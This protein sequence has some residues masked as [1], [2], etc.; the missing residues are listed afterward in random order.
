MGSSLPAIARSVSWN[1]REFLRSVGAVGLGAASLG[2]PRLRAMTPP[3]GQKAVVVTF[4][5][6]ARD[7]ETFA[8]EGQENIP[9]LLHELI[10]QATFFTQA[11]NRGILGHY[12]ATA[13]L[14][15][16]VYETINN[17]ASLPPQNPSVRQPTR[18]WLRLATD[19]I[20]SA[21]AIIGRM[22]TG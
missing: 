6:G 22:A 11:V 21:K 9:H 4:G 8:P 13:S 20:A 5:G 7:E 10:P 12:V 15:T 19:S 18:G 3:R 17:F 16:G 2:L 1:R 14:A